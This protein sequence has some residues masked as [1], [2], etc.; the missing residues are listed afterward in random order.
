MAA[1]RVIPSFNELEDSHACFDLGL[2]TALVKELAVEG[3]K[4]TLAHGAVEAVAY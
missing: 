2:E 1:M 3:G 4:E